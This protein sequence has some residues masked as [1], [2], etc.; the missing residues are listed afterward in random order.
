[1]Q[2]R[3]LGASGLRVSSVALGTMTWGRD[4]D[5]HEAAE[6]LKV[7]LEAGGTLLDTSA[8]YS[9]GAAEE[10][11][12]G[13]LGTVVEREEVLLCSKAGV[14]DGRVDASRGALLDGLAGTLRR[15][16]T[17]HLDLWLVQAPDP[18][19]P[20][21]ETISA[22]RHAVESGRARY[23]GLANHPAWQTARAAT[24]LEREGP[25]LAAVQMEYSLLQRGI[26]RELAPAAMA[27]GA[28]VLAWSPLGRGVLSG[29]YRRSVPADSRAA[30][31]HLRG[32]VEPYL[33]DRSRSV[34]E[35]VVTA[36][37]G[38][39]RAPVEVALA[40]VRDAPGV[41]SAVVG[42]RTP[43]QLRG[44]LAGSDLELPDQI[45]EALDE[46]TAPVLGYPERR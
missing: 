31:P 41:S 30:S 15:L 21:E 10:V 44:S 8:T 9:G 2:T 1:M 18:G 34:V 11:I 6:Q 28:G 22:L 33:T 37:D 42:A 17:D 43:A 14:R 29:K 7:F 4:T 24:L 40:W 12:G 19:T 13:L 23:V 3:R 5:E 26:E 20:L 35:A 39:G 46:I 27:L 38:L 32:F 36:A 25:S 45:R 16:G